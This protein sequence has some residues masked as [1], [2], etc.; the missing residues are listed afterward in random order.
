M[1]IGI[2]LI[3]LMLFISVSV[4]KQ[5][6]INYH[7]KNT[8]CFTQN[9]VVAALL[10]FL[11]FI[12]YS[13]WNIKTDKFVFF[14][15]PL[16]YVMLILNFV[17]QVILRKFTKSNE[18]NM[19]FVKFSNFVFIALVPIVSYLSVVHLGFG[20]AINVDYSNLT[21]V[22]ILS[23]IIGVLSIFLFY[24]KIKSKV[25]KRLDL[26]TLSILNS[27]LTVVFFV[28]LMQEYDTQAVYFCAIFFNTIV[29]LNMT[30]RNKE[31]ELIE[32]S[33]IK[34]L[35]FASIGYI[36]YSQVNMMVVNILPAEHIAIF[37]AI[38]GVVIAS[39]FDY[40]ANN[41]KFNLNV[42]D[43]VVLGLIFT[44]LFYFKY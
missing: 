6:N 14:N 38:A 1:L 29:W 11:F 3:T 25:F 22:F 34:L 8:I 36:I 13:E 31:F 16:F 30:M 23:G 2:S 15:D 12:D 19:V 28:K 44:T 32:K 18:N 21:Q 39:T 24:D 41:K 26:M 10:F 35:I 4:H 17:N 33:N 5:I 37:R 42:K 27:S 20:S 43:F 7:I 9:G 40:Y